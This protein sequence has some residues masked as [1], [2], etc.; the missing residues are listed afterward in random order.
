[1]VSDQQVLANITGAAFS[2]IV[3][4]GAVSGAVSAAPD[5]LSGLLAVR[6]SPRTL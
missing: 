1:M 2:K 6:G 3:V 4:L 5:R